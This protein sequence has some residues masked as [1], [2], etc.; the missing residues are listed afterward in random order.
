MPDRRALSRP[1]STADVTECVWYLRRHK[2][3]TQPRIPGFRA[4]F[5]PCR[6]PAT[7]SDTS[8]ARVMDAGQFVAGHDFGSCTGIPST[9]VPGFRAYCYRALGHAGTG[10]PGM[11]P[12]QGTGTPGIPRPAKRPNRLHFLSSN[13]VFSNRSENTP[14]PGVRFLSRGREQPGGPWPTTN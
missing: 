9:P 14:T 12:P 7:V 11:I 2:P 5:P 6:S 3:I 4:Y 13:S 10:I 8:V 1:R